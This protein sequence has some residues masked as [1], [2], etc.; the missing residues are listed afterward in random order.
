MNELINELVDAIKEDQRYIHFQKASASLN[1]DDVL[2]LM[3]EYQ[4]VVNDLNYLQQFDAYID[5]SDKKNEFK[6]IKKKLAQNSIV[7]DYYQAYYQINDLLN[8]V[9][10]IVFQHIS[11]SLNTTGFQL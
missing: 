8:E 11:D 9:T 3:N 5:I 6:E 1:N 10:Q 7:Q 4:N 2:E